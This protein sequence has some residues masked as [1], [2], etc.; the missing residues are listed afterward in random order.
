MV[1][2]AGCGK[3]QLIAAALMSHT[4]PRP[5]RVL[6]H[7]NAGVA[8]LRA[9]LS[10][11]GVPPRRYRLSTIDGWALRLGSL[12]PSR[13]GVR[14]QTMELHN[15]TRDYP[16]L[17][18]RV[19][20]LIASGH[21]SNLLR[22]TYAHVFV[23]EYQ[24][25]SRTQHALIK[26]VADILPVVVLGDPMQAIF[27]FSLVDPLADWDADVCA[28]FPEAATLDTPWRW[29]N[30]G[31]ED[32]GRWLLDVR[33]T[34][35]RGDGVDI[36][37]AP[38]SVQLI[39]LG[40]GQE[41]YLQ[42]L[43]A[44]RSPAP[45]PRGSVLI[46]ADSRKPA[47]QRRFASQIPGAVTVEAVDLKDF[48]AFADALEFSA[49]DVLRRVS[50]FAETIMANASADDLIAR[51]AALERGRTRKPATD[52]E[53]AAC[54]FKAAPS[55]NTMAELLEVLNR[56]GG[57]R[58]YRPTVLRAC[59]QALQRCKQDDGASF[60]KA[61]RRVREE[62]RAGLRPVARRAVGSTLLLKGLE[63]DMAVILN[64]S[65]MRARHLYVAMTRGARRLILCSENSYLTPAA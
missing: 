53:A 61:A 52:A 27:D 32:L 12:F 40:S 9:R 51:V 20:A 24:D 62:Y 15:P 46:I 55:P 1:A 10:L 25:C 3:T 19:L 39:R 36:M 6:T 18:H 64:A 33:E 21:I 42:Q 30:V 8:A 26:L 16:E 50:G 41:A 34:L 49:D 37:S 29:R 11:A 5:V 54:R 57:V 14:P 38:T 4:G 22:S 63:A 44:A 2:P 7:T 65:D 23:D 17:R 43:R 60:G 31:N 45:V 56:Q 59:F 48:I 28:C 13:S 58:V 47:E 35:R